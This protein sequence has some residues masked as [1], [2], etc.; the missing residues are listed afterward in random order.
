MVEFAVVTSFHFSSMETL[1]TFNA[2]FL[3][4]GDTGL[5]LLRVAVG[6]IFLVHGVKKLDGKMGGFMTF[7]GVC[8]ALGGLALVLGLL[9]QLA[10]LGLAIIMLGAIYK[11]TME[12]KVPFTTMKAMGWEFDL[13]LLGAC[14]AL[15]TLGAGLYSIDMNIGL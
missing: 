4:Y 3:A 11:K 1:Q 13:A 14:I 2:F 7:I 8:E 6:A 5:L 12:W 10:G 15:L 9:T